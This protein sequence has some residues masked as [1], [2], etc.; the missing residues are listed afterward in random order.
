MKI[1]QWNSKVGVISL[2]NTEGV[3]KR[4]ILVDLTQ[5]PT[6]PIPA[7]IAFQ[8]ASKRRSE[9]WLLSWDEFG[10]QESVGDIGFVDKTKC[11]H[12]QGVRY[13]EIPLETSTATE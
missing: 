12:L 7:Q 13:K 10:N 3:G 2:D 8:K 1:I 5:L 6:E 11:K 4:N 9:V